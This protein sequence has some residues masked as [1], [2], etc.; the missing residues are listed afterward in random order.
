MWCYADATLQQ[1]EQADAILPFVEFWRHPSG[2]CPARLICDSHLTTYRT[3]AQRDDQGIHFITLRRRG[4]TLWQALTDSP[5]SAW[6]RLRLRGVKR[7]YRHGRYQAS[8][9]I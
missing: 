3:L 9:G 4:K 1:R 8:S 7:R 6:Q 5:P 2:T